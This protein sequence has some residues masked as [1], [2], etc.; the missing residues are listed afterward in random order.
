MG[1]KDFFPKQKS[2]YEYTWDII[3]CMMIT[4]DGYSSLDIWPEIP[5]QGINSEN[6][7]FTI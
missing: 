3:A 4:G 6:M 5:N 1:I 2:F 7:I